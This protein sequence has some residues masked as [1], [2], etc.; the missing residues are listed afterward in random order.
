MTK[1]NASPRVDHNTIAAFH[2]TTHEQT[3][4]RASFTGLSSLMV[5]AVLELTRTLRPA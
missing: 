1:V 2:L 5:A 3:R 4:T